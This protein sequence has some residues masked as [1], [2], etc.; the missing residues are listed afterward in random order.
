[1]C[2]FTDFLVKKMGE[3][4]IFNQNEKYFNE[5]GFFADEK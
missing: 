3:K 2:K 5:R 4:A 1:M